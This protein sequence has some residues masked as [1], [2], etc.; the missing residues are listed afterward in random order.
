MSVPWT[1]KRYM[2]EVYTAGI[3]E[4]LCRSDGRTDEDPKKNY[5]TGGLLSNKKYMLSLTFNAPKEA[6]EDRIQYLF[7]GRSVD[8]L[9]FHIHANFRFFAMKTLPTFACH[10]VMKNPCIQQDVQRLR[11]HIDQN[12]SEFKS[13]KEV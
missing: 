2:D 6:F 5:G 8:D 1:T 9:F 7:R 3:G 13:I 11:R 4:R 10:D 12:F